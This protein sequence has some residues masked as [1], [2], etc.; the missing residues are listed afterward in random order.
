MKKLSL[1]LESLDVQSFPTSDAS[2]ADRGTVRGAEAGKLVLSGGSGACFTNCSC[3]P[4]VCIT[5]LEQ[6]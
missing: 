1:R 3:E 2:G 5:H 6:D 4:T